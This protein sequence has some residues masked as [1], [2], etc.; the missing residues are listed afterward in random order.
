MVKRQKGASYFFFYILF[1]PDTWR[2]L[3]GLLAAVILAPAVATPE[4][5]TYGRTVLYL[6]I[7]AIGYAASGA[8]ARGITRTLKNLILGNKQK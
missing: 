8:P 7:T 4:I 5:D 1:L 2:I 6:M 3:V